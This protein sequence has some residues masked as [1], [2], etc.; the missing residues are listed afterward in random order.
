MSIAKLGGKGK[1]IVEQNAIYSAIIVGVVGVISFGLGY[2]S[3]GSVEVSAVAIENAYP[4]PELALQGGE[5]ILGAVVVDEDR[6]QFVASRS[7]SK[8]HYPWCSGAKRIK[9]ENKLWFATK[10]DAERAG[11]EPAKNC[12]GL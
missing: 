5:S 11:Y 7:G 1:R 8:Y 4:T 2:L 6:G 10:E 12:E 9:E 3:R